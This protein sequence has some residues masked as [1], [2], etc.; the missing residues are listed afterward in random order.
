MLAGFHPLVAGWFERRFG[1][2]TEPQALGWPAIQEG[3]D[4]LLSAPTGSGKTF[5]AFLH[6]LDGLFRDGLA[7]A[8]PDETRILY[9]SPL[10]ALSNDIELNLREPLAALRE[11]AVAAGLPA[12]SIRAAVRTGDTPASRRQ[13]MLKRPPHVLVT[14]PESGTSGAATSPCPWSGSRRWPSAAPSASACPRR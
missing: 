3:R 12:P 4:V 11:A 10:K 9:V 14:T 13:A 7:G 6:G 5:A 2:P 1:T 8:L